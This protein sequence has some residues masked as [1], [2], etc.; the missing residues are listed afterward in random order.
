MWKKIL[1]VA[2]RKTSNR[3]TGCVNSTPTNSA[4]T[5]LHSMITFHHANTRGSRAAWLKIAHLCVA[6]QLSSTC[7]VSFLAAPD[8]DHKH[9]FSFTYFSYL[10]DDL[11]DTHKT[12][13]TRCI[14]LCDGPRQSGGS[15]QISSYTN[16]QTDKQTNRQT[17]KRKHWDNITICWCAVLGKL[18]TETSLQVGTGE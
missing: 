15:T 10:S 8:T 12:F 16:R 14:F 3:P 11:T 5:E 7:H 18:L 4:R 13:G 1:S 2:W 17:H 9:K 6:K